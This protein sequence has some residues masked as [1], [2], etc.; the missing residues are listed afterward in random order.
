MEQKYENK[1]HP[2]L[3]SIY[4]NIGMVNLYS[5]Q[6][7]KSLKY[8]QHSLMVQRKITENDD[9]EK[10]EYHPHIISSLSIIGL[11]YYALEN[12]DLSLSTFNYI[13]SMQRKTFGYNHALVAM[14]LNNI[15]CVHFQQQ[16]SFN[17]NNSY[18]S[19]VKSLEESID[20]ILQTQ[21]QQDEYDSKNILARI[22]M[23]YGFV[24]I[25]QKKYDEAIIVLQDTLQL[26]Q[27]CFDRNDN[28]HNKNSGD[29]VKSNISHDNDRPVNCAHNCN[30]INNNVIWYNAKSTIDDLAYSM[31]LANHNH[32]ETNQDENDI[33]Y[34]KDEPLENLI[35]M[36]VDMLRW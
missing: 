21:K 12:Y 16:S 23:N 5:K 2:L 11:I 22:D 26:F 13:L 24:R 32:E 27:E 19:C 33:Y 35:T 18:I 10:H 31:A 14:T 15:A 1:N 36:Y 4:H 28:V 29:D 7:K 25:K 8:F 34:N 20:I 6:Y 3:A 9:M 17:N 30:W